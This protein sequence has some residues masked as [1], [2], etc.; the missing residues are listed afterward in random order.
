MKKNI[1][2]KYKRPPLKA[3]MKKKEMFD[4]CIRFPLSSSSIDELVSSV[5]IS[6][7]TFFNYFDTIDNFM[8]QLYK[9]IVVIEYS[10]NKKVEL[11]QI[12]E[13]YAYTGILP[14]IIKYFL[15]KKSIYYS[16]L[17]LDVFM[18]KNVAEEE[19]NYL[20]QLINDKK[21]FTSI[22]YKMIL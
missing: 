13:K 6:R 16:Q 2:D 5:Y 4:I 21:L 18:N 1:F 11:E 12:V 19:V 8:L 15:E 10:K 7:G 3:E 20:T 17:E 22:L 9:Y 14:Y